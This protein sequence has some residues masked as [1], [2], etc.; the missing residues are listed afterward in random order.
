MRRLG[1]LLVLLAGGCKAAHGAG[2]GGAP[3]HDGG[4][5]APVAVASC[6]PDVVGMR[7][8]CDGSASTDPSG[9]A[10]GY[11]WSLSTVPSGST[12]TASGSDPS[13]AFAADRAGDYLVSLTVTTLDGASATTTVTAS[14]PAIAIFFRQSRIDKSSGTFSFNRVLSDGSGARAL[15]CALTVADPSGGDA[16]A[17]N[18]DRYGSMPAGFGSRAF[19]P[20]SGGARVVFEDVTASEHHLLASDEAGDCVARPPVRLDAT[21]TVAHRVPRFSPDGSRVAWIDIASSSAQLYT[22]ALD[23]SA[24]HLVRTAAKLK[25]APPQWLDAGHLAWVEDVSPDQTPHLQIA[26]AADADGAGDG[27]GRAVEVDCP[28][29]ADP[30]ALQVIN[31]FALVG[32]AYLVAGGVKSRTAN[33]PGATNLYR[34]AGASCSATSA[35]TLAVEPSGGFAWDFAVSPDGSTLVMAAAEAPGAAAHDLFLVPVDGSVPPSRFVGS[36]PGLDDVGPSW[37]AGGRQI[38]WTQITTDGS[39]G[40]GGIMIANRDGSSIRSLVPQQGDVHV[41]GALN[42][43]LDCSASG[44]AA[45]VGDALLLALALTLVRRSRRA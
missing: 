32:G 24:R 3:T 7:T 22:A 36:A 1:V 41:A 33:P 44:G 12:L 16:G 29:A 25:S 40:G 27:S 31:Q 26:S 14:V 13:F 38:S 17:G 6:T 18:L 28:A 34:L 9:R 11:A 8:S 45:A 42:R 30:A 19:Y 5:A 15:G 39:A 4:A 21:P 37:L 2:D 23:G 10:L 20:A 43:G 35:A